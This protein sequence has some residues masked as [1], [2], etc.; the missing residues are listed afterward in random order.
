MPSGTHTGRCS[1]PPAS[2]PDP[3]A[4]LSAAS[5]V[6]AS[7]VSPSLAPPE[8]RAPSASAACR[9]PPCLSLSV[10]GIYVPIIRPRYPRM[11]VGPC[12]VPCCSSCALEVCE[13]ASMRAGRATTW[14]GNARGLFASR[15]AARFL[16]RTAHAHL[17]ANRKFRACTLAR[18]LALRRSNRCMRNKAI[19]PWRVRCTPFTPRLPHRPSSMGKGHARAEGYRRGKRNSRLCLRPRCPCCPHPRSRSAAAVVEPLA[20]RAACPN[21]GSNLR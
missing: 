3:P 13:E 4:P 2:S 16:I 6:L 7:S 19:S 15:V 11:S 17:C 12:R 9:G 5:N 14:L 21:T 18:S 20:S 10:G 8:P 1:T